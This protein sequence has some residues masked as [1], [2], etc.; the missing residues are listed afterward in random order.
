MMDGAHRN[1]TIS[2]A[3]SGTGSVQQLGSG[4]TT[5]TGANTYLGGTTFGA[6]T[7]SVD[8][9]AKLGDAAGALSFNG[10][11]LQV[12]G[13]SFTS[14]ARTINWQAG[15][16][17]FDI[18]DVNNTFTVNQA[19][20]G[21]GSLRK[22][23]AGTLVLTGTNTYAGNTTISAG[24]LRIGDGS[25]NGSIV[26]NVANSGTLAFNRSDIV[27]F[28]GNITGATG[29]VQ[30]IGT[31][32]TILTGTSSY[33]GGTTISAGVLQLGNGGTTGSISGD[34]TNNGRL[35]INRSN[36]ITLS[37]VISGNGSV[38]QIGG[39]TTTLSGVNTYLGG[40]TLTAGV[41]SVSA[42]ANLGN[43]AG[44]LTFNGGT[45]RVTG[46]TFTST[47]RTID[48]QAGGGGFNILAALNS[49]TV[50]QALGGPGGL[51]KSGPGTLVLTGTNT[52]S[53]GTT[54][55]AGVLQIGNGGAT[56]SIAGDV[57]NDGT[58]AFNR[59]NAMTFSGVI[60][61]T[62]AVQQLG[63]GTTILTADNTYTGGTTISAGIL[64]IGDGGA[65]GSIAGNVVNNATLAFNRTGELAFSGVISG[66][67]N[68]VKNGSGSVV[69][70]GDSSAFAGTT[71][72]TG[73]TLRVNG[74]LGGA[75][76][77]GNGAVLGGNGTIGSGPG[78]AVSVGAGGAISPGNSIGTLTIAGNLTFAAGSIFQ[79]E[80]AP[81]GTAA[82]LV[83]VTGN[84]ILNGGSVFHI[85]ANGGYD[86][87]SQYTILSADGTLTGSFEKVTSNFAFLTPGLSYDYAG[88]KVNLLLNRNDVAFAA[89]AATPNQIATGTAI[90]SI[91]VAANN[92]L[93][94][95]IA[96]LPSNA[97]VVQAAFD[98]LSGEIHGSAKT[99]LIDDSSHV[100]DA[101]TDRIASAFGDVG[102]PAL[103]VMAYGDGGAALAPA[104]TDRLAVWGNG[105]GA[106]ARTASD[107]N[108]AAFRHS[109]GGFVFGADAPVID[110]WR[111]GLIGGYSH[112]AFSATDRTSSGDSDNW[113]LGLYGGGQWGGLGVRG[114]LAYTWHDMATQRSVTFLGFSDSLQAKYRAGTFQ[115]F[116][117]VGY[118]IDTA[119][120]RFEPF[121]NLAYVSLHT[122]GFAETG[123][124][125]ALSVAGR[126][127]AVTV[128]TL[129]VRAS[130]DFNLAGMQATARGTIGWRHASGDINP[131]STH[132]FSAGNS[133]TVAGAPI[134]RNAALIEAGLDVNVATSASLGIAYE[135]L[136]AKAAA[137]HGFKVNFNVKF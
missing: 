13:T 104:D 90:D 23:G 53:G 81:A 30:Q 111:L 57:A 75:L 105:F 123:G 72:I 14:T 132:A 27:V 28:S 10:G 73:G 58:L 3:I 69:L 18:A 91:G 66:A 110:G 37:G 76:A 94:N 15:G 133:F 60:G 67:G 65:S 25:T 93:H 85:G 117:D 84:V 38:E 35:L 97:A 124:A 21:T 43:V 16:G 83:H 131:L 114:G 42:D 121:A 46:T 89:L 33:G 7:L 129:G 22:L 24:T 68:L 106:W 59:S 47:A 31:G 29:V 128:A 103:P 8:A 112:T 126:T 56:G 62:G 64:Q 134:A 71:S 136:L 12:T 50:S 107:G 137:R 77:V 79:V 113:H 17:G 61:G 115:A 52:Y 80:V 116:G 122:N 48:W 63:A 9:D 44:A 49:F 118:R 55:S 54:I 40:T 19:L 32:T 87:R 125:A 99:A 92:P 74:K 1:F 6:G 95:A 41:L 39:G 120:A 119:A 108:A 88:R 11:A 78:S 70:S 101:A 135:G 100:R 130:T 2:G 34:V 127:T 4:V 82:D 20:G 36:G 45:L 5:L 26:G 102:A 51:A 98:Q 86:L 96:Q 109:S